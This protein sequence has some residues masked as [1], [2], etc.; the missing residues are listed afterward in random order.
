[1]KLR[2]SRRSLRHI[3]SILSYIAAHDRSAA[4]KVSR[5]VRDSTAMLLEFPGAGRR[6]AQTGTREFVVPG[7]PYIVVYRLV[8]GGDELRIVGIYHAAQLRPGQSRP[9]DDP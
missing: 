8:D 2:Y 9:T 5:R 1:M 4:A 6:G 7:L 3:D